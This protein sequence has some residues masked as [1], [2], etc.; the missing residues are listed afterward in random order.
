L[1]SKSKTKYEQQ[2]TKREQASWQ[3]EVDEMLSR[4]PTMLP[5]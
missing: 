2:P 1:A 5:S 3:K 4:N